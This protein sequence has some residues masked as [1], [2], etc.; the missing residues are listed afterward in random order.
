[1]WSAFTLHRVRTIVE[2]GVT[3]RRSAVCVMLTVVITLVGC[4]SDSAPSD[5]N[6]ST[7][8]EDDTDASSGEICPTEGE[9]L[10]TAKLYIEHNATDADTGIHGF[11]GGEAW[12]ELC[13]WDPG[14][15]LIL[16]VEPSGPLG[17]LRV[18]DL[19]F[20]SREPPNDEYA[21]DELT[22][23]FA[24]GEYLVGG[25]DFEGVPRVATA[26]FSH[27]IPA[28]PMIT[29]PD[30]AEDEDEAEEAVVSMTDL[31][32]QWEAVSETLAGDP[33][34]VTGYE[35]IVTKEEHE[36]PHG[37]SQPIYDVHVGPETHHL[38][39]AEEFLEPATL[40]EL[41]VLVLETSGNQT[42]GLGFFTT[43]G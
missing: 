1:M 13:V 30:L 8:I 18:A 35:V 20:E 22:A 4:E 28:E 21:V 40:Y 39:I 9:E 3:M 33:I 24:E 34:T 19:F 17:D 36:D 6:A 5:V 38:A 41:E 29:S 31:V 32:V 15:E 11:F 10:E 25:T 7:S 23:A 2:K 27:D 16:S 14:G 42:I 12:S 37:W 43:S 26:T